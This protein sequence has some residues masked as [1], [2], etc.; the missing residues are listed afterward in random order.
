MYG[1]HPGYNVIAENGNTGWSTIFA[2][3]RALQINLGINEVANNFAAITTD[4]F[5]LKYLK[6]ILQQANN[7]D[8]QNKVI[9]L[10]RLQ[11]QS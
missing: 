4:R 1:S 10:S 5:K 3:T 9:G 2:F 7:D 8:T 11:R 6:E